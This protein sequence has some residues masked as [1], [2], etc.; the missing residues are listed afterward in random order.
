[1]N[2]EQNVLEVSGVEITKA[3][4]VDLQKR[5]SCSGEPMASVYADNLL[6]TMRNMRD[7][8]PFDPYKSLRNTYDLIGYLLGEKTMGSTI[9]THRQS[10]PLGRAA[11][12]AGLGPPHMRPPRGRGHHRLGGGLRPDQPVGEV[13]SSNNKTVLRV[14]RR[15]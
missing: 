6:R 5:S 12:S 7:K 13:S 3:I 4:L 2:I 8:L 10:P 15:Q 1:M 14:T 9:T 11:A